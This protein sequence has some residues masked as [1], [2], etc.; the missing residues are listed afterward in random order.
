MK[1]EIILLAHPIIFHIPNSFQC[2]RSYDI[3]Y[4]THA[5]TDLLWSDFQ[6]FCVWFACWPVGDGWRQWCLWFP[7]VSDICFE[8]NY[9]VWDCSF[10][11]IYLP[12]R[13][14]PVIY[15]SRPS[16]YIDIS[17][18]DSDAQFDI[19]GTWILTWRR[20]M[21][22][23]ICRRKAKMPRLG[24]DLAWLHHSRYAWFHPV[25]S[26]VP[27]TRSFA[28]TWRVRIGAIFQKLRSRCQTGCLQANTLNWRLA[29]FHANSLIDM[30]EE[31]CC[32]L[33][34]CHADDKIYKWLYADANS[35][36]SNGK[37]VSRD[38]SPWILHHVLKRGCKVHC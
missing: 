27:V 18:Y 6:S 37:Q 20:A 10:A 23:R 14:E 2:A 16:W 28:S 11:I 38:T 25:L 4:F 5:A 1:V 22:R 36:K 8:S 32:N 26:L 17:G 15:W 9:V 30:L 19:E 31:S 3:K 33:L 21:C 12:L 24:V 7:I 35:S 29:D 34:C 13:S